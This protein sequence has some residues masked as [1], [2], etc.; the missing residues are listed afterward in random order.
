MDNQTQQPQQSGKQ[1][2]INAILQHENLEPLQTPFRITDPKMAEWTSMFDSTTPIALNPS[3]TKS[4]GR[5]K[6]LYLQNQADLEPAV[7]EQF[8][9]YLKRNPEITIQDAI[10]IFDQ[11]GAAGKLKFLQGKGFDPAAKLASILS[12]QVTPQVELAPSLLP[13]EAPRRKAGRKV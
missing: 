5:E 4:K 9:R 13:E 6:F 8:N 11:S 1:S 7:Q 12:P 10:K 2:L 3:A